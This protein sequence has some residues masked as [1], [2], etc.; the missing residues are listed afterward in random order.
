MLY[1]DECVRHI[2]SKRGIL[3]CLVIDSSGVPVRSTMSDPETVEHIGLFGQLI[4][5]ARVIMFS[6]DSTD[7][8]ISLR[9]RSRK[10]E[11]LITLD[12]LFVFLVVQ[13]STN[14]DP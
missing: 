13:K 7:E 2:C 5:R 1:V 10:H 12:E 9:V 14:I 8:I 4:D 6:F 3:H 11:I